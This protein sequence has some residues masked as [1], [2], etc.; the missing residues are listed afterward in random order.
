MPAALI[1]IDF[2]NDIV[3]EVGKLAKKGYA[4]FVKKNEVFQKL[5]DALQHAREQKIL[6]I[7]V[8]IGFSPT[9][10][11]QPKSSPVFGSAHEVQALR[12]GEWGTQFHEQVAVQDTDI[13]ITKHRVSAFYATPLDLIL[14]N[15]GIDSIFVAGVATDLAVS[16]TVRDAHDRDYSVTVL[17]DCCAAASE[18]DH[19]SALLSLRKIA[20]VKNGEADF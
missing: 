5:S 12:L 9:Y 11:E 18:E 19:N 10:I 16:N 20:Q 6:V 13:I 2:I 3:H 8:R 17:A 15:N 14:K 1:L 4:D 7:H